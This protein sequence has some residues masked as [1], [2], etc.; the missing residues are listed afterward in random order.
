MRKIEWSTGE[1]NRVE[2]RCEKYSGVQVR[3]IEWSTVEKN[4]VEYRCEK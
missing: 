4:R 1:K 3:K 2:H